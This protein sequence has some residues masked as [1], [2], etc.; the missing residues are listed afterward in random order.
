VELV[1][2]MEAVVLADVAI[3]VVVA[4]AP[5]SPGVSP[6]APDAFPSVYP[7]ALCAS[8]GILTASAHAY[9]PW[10]LPSVALSSSVL[11][12]RGQLLRL[13]AVVDPSLVVFVVVV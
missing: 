10:C 5:F 6:L 13:E 12:Q 3:A 1:V 4:A 11:Q 8:L 9:P 7:L 2:V